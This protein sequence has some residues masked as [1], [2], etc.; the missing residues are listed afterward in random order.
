MKS[1]PRLRIARR[2][3]G[4]GN[5]TAFRIIGVGNLLRQ[6]TSASTINSSAILKELSF[7]PK[8]IDLATGEYL[9]AE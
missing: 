1:L 9:I 8:R 5:R 4:M 6:F 7:A 2:E 3:P